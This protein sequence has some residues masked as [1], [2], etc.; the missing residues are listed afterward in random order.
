MY[1]IV[2]KKDNCI[3]KVYMKKYLKESEE[4]FFEFK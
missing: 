1:I 3:Q 4:F 2:Y